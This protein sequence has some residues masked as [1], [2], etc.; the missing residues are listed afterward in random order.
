MLRGEKVCEVNTNE[1]DKKE[2]PPI[3][4]SKIMMNGPETLL[5][6]TVKEKMFT[7]EIV[8]KA[9]DWAERKF[10]GDV[11]I[12]VITEG[13]SIC[14]LP[15]NGGGVYHREKTGGYTL[16]ITAATEDD[17]RKRLEYITGW[18]IQSRN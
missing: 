3:P 10:G 5:V 2:L 1:G 4:I 13:Q 15:I 16:E 18:K 9:E 8:K 14:A 11:A 12:V 7:E 6:F 17:L